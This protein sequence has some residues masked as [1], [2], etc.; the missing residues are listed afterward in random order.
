MRVRILKWFG[1]HA[2]GEV[3][4]SH[5]MMSTGKV[6]DMEQDRKA[7]AH[8]IETGW[9]EAIE[10]EEEVPATKRYAKA[11]LNKSREATAGD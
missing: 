5:V 9:A 6:V 11:P 2:P 8:W 7:F 3:C 10:D 1:N 4:D